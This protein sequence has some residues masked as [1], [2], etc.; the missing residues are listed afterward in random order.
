MDPNI[1][2]LINA[3]Y[4]F[5]FV[6]LMTLSVGRMGL[7]IWKYWRAHQPI[8]SLL[9]RDFLFAS[10]LTTPFLTLL[11][12]RW[13]GSSI[14]GEPWY[15]VWVIASGALALFGTAVLAFYEYFKIDQ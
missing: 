2:A 13:M 1:L 12:F 10:G 5:A 7:R 6:V 9:K 8:P 15:P 4:L 3:F 11:F 14:S